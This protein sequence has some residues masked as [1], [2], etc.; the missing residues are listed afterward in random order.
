MIVHMLSTKLLNPI[1]TELFDRVIKLNISVVFNIQ[2]LF[3]V[4]KIIR[5][6]PT[7]YFIMKILNKRELQQ[8]LLNHSSDIDLKALWIY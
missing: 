3:A 6:N 4:P 5:L 2:S 7:H 1:L 8:F